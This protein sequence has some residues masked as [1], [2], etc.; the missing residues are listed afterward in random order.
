MCHTTILVRSLWAF[1]R[2]QKWL[3]EDFLCDWILL[4]F[5]E[6]DITLRWHMVHSSSFCSQWLRECKPVF[7]VRFLRLGTLCNEITTWLGLRYPVV[8]FHL[9]LCS[10]AATIP[11]IGSLVLTEH[12][13][14][15]CLLHLL[16]AYV[17]RFRPG[18]F[19]ARPQTADPAVADW[20]ITVLLKALRQDFLDFILCTVLVVHLLSN[21]LI[22]ILLLL[23]DLSIQLVS[24]FDWLLHLFGP[25]FAILI[26]NFQHSFIFR[27]GNVPVILEEAALLVI[28]K[29]ERASRWYLSISSRNCLR[30]RLFF[31]CEVTFTD[32][33]RVA[34]LYH[35]F[36][37]WFRVHFN[38]D[39]RL[40]CGCT[41]LY[42]SEKPIDKVFA[43]RHLC[44]VVLVVH[45]LLLRLIYMLLALLVNF[46]DSVTVCDHLLDYCTF[47]LWNNWNATSLLLIFLNELIEDP[48]LVRWNIMSTNHI[49]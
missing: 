48:A 26:I 2:S 32:N 22:T 29:A 44:L 7:Q 8:I 11:Q 36:W 46:S 16:T 43:D 47:T 28:I 23:V 37:L 30:M 42:I 38:I 15:D 24:N 21:R 17:S 4:N 20:L 34:Y 40:I 41:P 31:I 13:T 45:V 12:G 5:A 27:V 18:A 39:F 3:D 9:R 35:D 49:I 25:D 6:R 33:W 19:L 14:R 10:F 1:C